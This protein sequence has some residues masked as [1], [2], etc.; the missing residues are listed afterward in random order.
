MRRLIDWARGARAAR[1]RR[2]GAGGQRTDAGLRAASRILACNACRRSPTWWRR[3]CRWS[4]LAPMETSALRL[5]AA[6]LRAARR[7]AILYVLSASADLHA[8]VRAGEGADGGLPGAGNRDVPQ[9][10]RLRGD[11]ADDRAQ[12]RP[13]GAEDA[14]A[15]GPRDA[16]GVRLHRHRD[17]GLRLRRAAAGHRDGA[18]LRH[19]AVP[20]HRVGAAAGRA[21]GAASGD[22]RGGG[23]GRRDGDAAALACRCRLRCRS[24]RWRS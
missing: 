5:A 16:H 12:R 9:H 17:V 19:A 21:R 13:V 3:G 1:D 4:S 7:H 6:D 23:P 20:D 8:G 22:R 18:R 15:G 24:A 14:P 11:A 10:R 2:P